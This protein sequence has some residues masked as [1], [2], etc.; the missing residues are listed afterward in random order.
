ME[1]DS[2]IQK[3]Q[4][5]C[6]LYLAQCS[7]RK[8][9]VNHNTNVISIIGLY[10]MLTFL[11]LAVLSLG[12]NMWVEARSSPLLFFE[13]LLLVSQFLYSVGLSHLFAPACHAG[14]AN[15]DIPTFFMNSGR[16]IYI[17]S[18]PLNWYSQ[19]THSAVDRRLSKRA[20]HPLVPSVLW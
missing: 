19:L 13:I 2:N 20:G 1:W 6:K 9:R 15:S 7:N 8:I 12:I 3:S 4:Y 18:Y 5:K 10:N 14:L 17:I 16:N 11:M